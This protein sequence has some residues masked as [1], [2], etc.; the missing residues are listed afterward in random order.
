MSSS[1]ALAVEVDQPLDPVHTG[2]LRAPAV[3]PH[4][5]RSMHALQQT[6]APYLGLRLRAQP[7]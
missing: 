7:D 5:D 3:V 2:F 4:P 1:L 6:R